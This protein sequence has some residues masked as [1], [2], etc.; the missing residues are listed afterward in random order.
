MSTVKTY[1]RNNVHR[2]EYTT[3]LMSLGN[4]S[5]MEK[6]SP[7]VNLIEKCTQ[8]KSTQKKSTQEK[9]SQEQKYKVSIRNPIS[10]GKERENALQ[11]SL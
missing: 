5:Q 10:L 2:K 7:L 9:M 11:N 3:E 4:K 1:P 8:K 6:M